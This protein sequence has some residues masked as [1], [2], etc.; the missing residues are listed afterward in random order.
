LC[1]CRRR[2]AEVGAWTPCVVVGCRREATGQRLTVAEHFGAPSERF[3]SDVFLRKGKAGVLWRFAQPTQRRTGDWDAAVA[4][5]SLGAAVG[6][7]VPEARGSLDAAA[8]GAHGDSGGKGSLKKRKADLAVVEVRA[9]TR[10]C[11][12]RT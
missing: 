8:A 7:L 10:A 12:M 9:R 11:L 3:T 6:A 5:A 2:V 4:R 1:R